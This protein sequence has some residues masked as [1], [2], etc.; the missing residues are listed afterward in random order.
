M[1][2]PLNDSPYLYGLHDPGG[3]RVMAERGT[4][5]W[6]LFTEAIGSDAAEQ[7]GVDYSP[8]SNQGYG[9]IVRLNNGYE[10][11][12]TIP[13]SS[14]YAEFA[15]RCGNFVRNSRGSHIW[16]IG[17]ETN[18][19][20]ER[21]GVH[22]DRSTNP[23]RI[24][25]PG[26]VILPGMYA[27]CYRQCRVQIKA[28]AGHGQDQVITAAPA[29][30]NNQTSY[31]GNTNGDW[32][33]YLADMLSA[34]GR[35][36]CDGIAIHAYTH[37]WNPALVYTSGTMDKPFQN[38]QFNFR[39]YRDFM[40]AIPANMRDL[41]VYL[42]E[43]NQD[44]PWHNANTGWVQRAYGEIEAWN[45]TPGT[46]VI[47]AV[48]LYRWSNADRWGIDGKAGVIEDFKLAMNHKYNWERALA[49]RPALPAE[50]T[51]TTETAQLRVRVAQLSGEVTALKA[52]IGRLRSA[53]EPPAPPPITDV[54]KT[55]P[56]TAGGFIKRPASDIKYLM[57]GH[58][59]V[60]ASVGPQQMAEAQR[61]KWPGIISQYYVNADGSVLQTEPI[62]EVVA[63]DQEWIYNGLIV[64]VAGNFDLAAPPEAQMRALARLLAWLLYRHQ[65]SELAI[66]GVSEFIQTKSPGA[67]WLTGQRWK[68]KLL[69]Y[70]R[71]IRPGSSGE[72][73]TRLEARV[74]E[75][76]AEAARLQE[77]LR[78][79]EAAQTA[80]Q[81]HLDALL[82]GDLAE[83]Q[84]PPITDVAARLPR[85]PGA[86]KKRA[87]SAIKHVV[88][89]HTSVASTVPAETIA[90]AHQKRWGAIT[91]HFF[92]TRDG[93]IQQTN[94]LDEVTDLRQPVLSQGIS[95]ALAGNFTNSAPQPAQIEAGATLIAWLLQEH[96]IPIENVK[97]AREWGGTASPGN[98]W[99][100]GRAWKRTL[101]EEIEAVQASAAPV[102]TR[103]VIVAGEPQELRAQVEQLVAE[104]ERSKTQILR[105][106]QEQ[107]LLRTSLNGAAVEKQMLQS[108]ITALQKQVKE[109]EGSAAEKQ[110][111]QSKLATLEAQV[112]ELE[113][114][115]AEKQ[116]LQS[117]IAALQAQV[118]ELES[119]VGEKQT[120]LAKI[121]TLE[122]RIRQLESSQTA[123]TPLP[124]KKGIAAPPIQNVV[125]KMPRHASLRYETRPLK[126]ITHLAIHHSAGPG[127]IPPY[128]IAA[129]HVRR[130]WPGI[131]YHFYIGPDGT[132]WQTNK[133]ETIS[134]NVYNANHYIVGICFAGRFMEGELPPPKQLQAAAQL[135]AWLMQELN[136]PLQNVRGHKELPQSQTACPGDQWL[137]GERWKDD[138]IA[139]ISSVQV[140]A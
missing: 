57:I 4:P 41:P 92:I 50:P 94:S 62:D 117:K 95:V 31:P 38:R 8:W 80:L 66:K 115:V 88:V 10:P 81:A 19:S 67:H 139:A 104:L 76:Q 28:Q 84:R 79:S 132:I 107:Q 78:A 93:V 53:A 70:V 101:L 46:Q 100:E 125:D 72:E 138:L 82:R 131:G 96:D 119:S 77:R 36:S 54:T 73:V 7:R 114:S 102:R 87:L 130:D 121:T 140:P 137:A 24:V 15:R 22:L 17:N 37:G 103:D 49:E 25:N 56:R 136:I 20:V 108:R 134:Y 127:T 91:Y 105:L 42:T 68:D 48:V 2:R 40:N 74:R 89:N 3:E 55:L 33:K 59:G 30:W 1:V 64:Y 112:I 6:I 90:L 98:Q 58:T 83:V 69:E 71:A 27:N 9:I 23:P 129:Y 120:L 128:N 85:N 99:T 106:R 5:G 111:L 123:T 110:T 113:S 43:T 26:E 32:V 39:A 18:F 135:C 52:E 44:E 16:I 14:H 47:R 34:I 124:T 45:R 63:K 29:P 65:L 118:K 122:A 35:A 133:L 13:H 12:G 86:L 116:A 21:P 126:N 75:L 61:S 97:G 60:A 51:E 11:A 109:L